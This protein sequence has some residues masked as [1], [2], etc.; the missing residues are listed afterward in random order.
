[1][2]W[3][4]LW[5]KEN[6]VCFALTCPLWKN[7]DTVIKQWISWASSTDAGKTSFSET[8]PMFMGFDDLGIWWEG[9]ASCLM[10]IASEE[11][12]MH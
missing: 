8:N 1:M 7:G 4:Q 9:E 11:L 2:A 10:F 5:P 3:L 12:G 6:V